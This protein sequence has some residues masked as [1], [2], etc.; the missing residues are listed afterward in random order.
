VRAIQGGASRAQLESVYLAVYLESSPMRVPNRRLFSQGSSLT[1]RALSMSIRAPPRAVL[2]DVL[3][4]LVRRG[5]LVGQDVVR[6][7]L[8]TDR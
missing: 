3:A 7:H 6:H 2:E 5:V 1:N 4:A 8:Q